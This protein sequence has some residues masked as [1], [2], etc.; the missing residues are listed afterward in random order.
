M[1]LHVVL[2]QLVSLRS[3]DAVGPPREPHDDGDDGSL[4]QEHDPVGGGDG[5][6]WQA[7]GAAGWKH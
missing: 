6:T 1:L 5:G 2:C 4:E 3:V 7:R